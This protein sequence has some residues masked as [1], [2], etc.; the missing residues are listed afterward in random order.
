IKL[1]F[2]TNWQLTVLASCAFLLSV[3]AGSRT[4]DGMSQFT[5][6]PVLSLLITFGIQGVMLII[7]WL[8]GESFA[9]GLAAG[10]AKAAHGGV[11][12]RVSGG[13]AGLVVG[14]LVFTAVA[15]LAALYLGLID[16]DRPAWAFAA[17]DKFAQQV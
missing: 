11:V 3:A 17:D 5:G 1:A 15:V 13:I 6:E 4:W 2:T 7:A 9:A 14:G 16:P 8:I 10:R 12:R